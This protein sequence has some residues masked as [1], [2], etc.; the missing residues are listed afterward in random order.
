VP[1][2]FPRPHQVIHYFPAGDVTYG[3]RTAPQSIEADYAPFV[4]AGRAVFAVV[5][6][7][8]PERE[9]PSLLDLPDPEK[10]EYV[11]AVAPYI[12]DLRRGLDYL[13]SRDDMDPNR[14]AFMGCSMGGI[15]MCLP[16][17]EPRYQ[18]VVF[19]CS[20]LRKSHAQVH[21]AANPVHFAPLI[22]QPKLL[23]HGLY[24]ETS[25]LRTDAEPLHRL[26]PQP[27]LVELYPGGHVPDPEDLTT[28]VNAWLDETFGPV[29]P[30]N[31]PR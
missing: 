11:N 27:K 24:D 9:G 6:S 5:L 3:L 26:L 20:V 16:A 7:G 8:Y 23:L 1:K 4:R 19:C 12:V 14:M 30:A 17:I 22:K 2:H 31:L 21:S 13:E 25:P 28:R 15:I 18:A 10:I 29:K